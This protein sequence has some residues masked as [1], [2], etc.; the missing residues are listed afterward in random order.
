VRFVVLRVRYL[1][2]AEDVDAK[3]VGKESGERKIDR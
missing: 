3:G 2:G 1:L